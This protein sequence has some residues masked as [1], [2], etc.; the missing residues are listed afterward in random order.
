MYLCLLMV[1]TFD[2]SKEIVVNEIL[3]FI[4]LNIKNRETLIIYIAIEAPEDKNQ[5]QKAKS[6]R[7]RNV[8]C[9]DLVSRLLIF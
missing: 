9:T 8:Y 4:F 6:I 1:N 3:S 7:K 5:M 2:K